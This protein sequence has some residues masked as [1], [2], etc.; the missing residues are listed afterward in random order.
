MD[1]TLEEE[2]DGKEPHMRR[3]GRSN[4]FCP[5][6]AVLVVVLRHRT[7]M[8]QRGNDVRPFFLRQEAG[9]LGRARKEEKG[10]HA[11]DKSKYTFLSRPISI[12]SRTSWCHNVLE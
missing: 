1:F 6:K 3:L 12:I 5:A 11:K 8:F 9:L 10:D 7:G 4:D 2:G